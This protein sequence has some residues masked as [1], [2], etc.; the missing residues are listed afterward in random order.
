[1][2]SQHPFTQAGRPVILDG[3]DRQGGMKGVHARRTRM[4]FSLLVA[5]LV[6]GRLSAQGGE[7]LLDHPLNAR[8]AILIDQ[9][10]GRVLFE[11]NADQPMVP[12]S[13]AKLMTL[14]IVYEKLEER[15]IHREDVVAI[16]SNA[17]ADNQAPG[18]SLMDLGPGQIVTLE[19]LMKGM[20]VASGNDAATALAEYV[21]GSSQKFVSQMNEEAA[22]LGYKVTRFTDPSGVGAGNVTTAREFAD[23]CRR[24]ITAHPEA[25]EEL[26]SLR[27]F[28]YP[29]RQNMADGRLTPGATKKQFNPNFL[30]WDD[31][32]VDGL[33]TG[34]LDNSNFTAA[35]TARRSD[36]RLI[37]VL[38]GVSGRSLKDGS[39]NRAQDGMSL[40]RY[41]FRNDTTRELDVPTLP[42]LRVWKGRTRDLPIAPRDP[43]YV[44]TNTSEWDN[45][46]YAV[47]VRT[48]LVAPVAR[49]E[50][51]GSLVY[52][53]GDQ[54]VARI[55]LFAA[56]TVE[57]AGI[58][59]RAWDSVVLTLSNVIGGP[60]AALR[61]TFDGLPPQAL[62]SADNTNSA[63]RRSP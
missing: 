36:M 61:A 26:H 46:A 38:L 3:M 31:F 60:T 21:A 10:T 16:T 9:T 49:G 44:T 39:R 51:V 52:T 58:A 18:S 28:D 47:D 53:S 55:P 12:A 1:M 23:F 54:E 27:E 34:H 56:E 25:L 11:H 8:S 14:H 41:G 5:C 57:P 22:F 35:I 7:A 33:K 2:R 17:W 29:L 4:A 59:R 48:P 62:L 40:L 20:A 32:G 19:E 37:A 24:Y 15:S 6:A 30:V 45:L 63:T 42:S 13:L 43:I 50:R